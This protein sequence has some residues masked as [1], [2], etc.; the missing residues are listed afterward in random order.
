MLDIDFQDMILFEWFLDRWTARQSK[1]SY[2]KFRGWKTKM[3]FVIEKM[4][5]M[6]Q[7]INSWFCFDSIVDKNLEIQEYFSN[8]KLNFQNSI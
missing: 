8:F 4:V 3:V 2:F 1:A 5:K 7:N 6:F